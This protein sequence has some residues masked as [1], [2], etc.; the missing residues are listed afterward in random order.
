MTWRHEGLVRGQKAERLCCHLR[1]L[2]R[3][4]AVRRSS[5]FA[6]PLLFPTRKPFRDP[7]DSA[8]QMLPALPWHSPFCPPPPPSP[9]YSLLPF[10]S[11]PKFRVFHSS[12]SANPVVARGSLASCCSGKKSSR[13]GRASKSNEELCHELREF[14]LA[15]GLPENRVPSMKELCEKGRKDLAN[16]VRRR[17]YKAITELLLNSNGESHSGKVLEGKQASINGNLYETAGGQERNVIVSPSCTFSSRNYSLE[18]MV[19][20]NG[21]VSTKNHDQVCEDSSESLHLKAAK[22][23]HTEELDIIKG[24]DTELYQ[25]WAP[26]AHEQHNQNEINHLKSL[27]DQK[28]V[29]LSQLKQQIENEK[30]AL[31]NLR[32]KGMAELGDIQRTI[33]EKDAELHAA[34]E[35]LDGL[36]EVHIDYW[37][38]G[39]TVEVTGS[40]NGWQHR[41]RLDLHPSS[42][43]TNPP[44]LRKPLLWT[45]VLWLYPGVYEIKFIVDDHWRIDFQREIITSGGITNNLLRVDG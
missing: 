5:T 31:S 8:L 12:W 18:D 44:G 25:D 3:R 36:K 33:A 26:K 16:I 15:I 29:E 2:P 1:S 27:L 35:N 23:E 11:F 39:Q 17:G 30:L 42:G 28:E 37:A 9:P 10:S 24:E 34:E 43:Q 14:N 45:T 32:A 7:S 6:K 22:F 20:S 41:V 40:F 19:K 38:N 13:R 21:A 4:S